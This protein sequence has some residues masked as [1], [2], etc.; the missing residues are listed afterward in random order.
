MIKNTF[1]P[2]AYN[3]VNFCGDVADLFN[4]FIENRITSD[5]AANEILKEAEDAFLKELTTKI[6]LLVFGEVNFGENL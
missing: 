4:R 3:K 1:K 5:F 6:H 2:A